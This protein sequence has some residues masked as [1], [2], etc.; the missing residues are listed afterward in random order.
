[1]PT[2]AKKSAKTE[3]ALLGTPKQAVQRM[4]TN[5]PDSASYEEIQYRIYALEK[6]QRG[7]DDTAAGRLYTHEE[8]EQKVEKWLTA[9]P[10]RRKRRAI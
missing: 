5:L 8:V 1:M 2:K 7:L 4:L 3:D 10:G 6:I 9:L